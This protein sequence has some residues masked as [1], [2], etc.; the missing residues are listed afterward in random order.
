[1]T[2]I[3]AE[4]K[5]NIF[6]WI[7][8]EEYYTCVIPDGIYNIEQLNEI[9]H[10]AQ[11]A[12]EVEPLLKFIWAE[13]LQRVFLEIPKDSGYM[14]NLTRYGKFY[15]VIGFE[16]HYESYVYYKSQLGENKVPNLSPSTKNSSNSYP[17]I[18]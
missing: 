11:R 9:L 8:D 18:L 10:F 5:N 7:L 14:I 1:M 6:E 4:L 12:E 13:T 15:E 16:P 2:H 3:S 17:N